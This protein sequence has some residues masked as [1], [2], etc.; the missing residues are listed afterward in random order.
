[1][2]QLGVCL[3]SVALVVGAAPLV[4]AQADESAAA[5]TTG[6]DWP[7]F[8][9]PTGDSKSREVGFDFAWPPTGLTVRWTRPLGDSYGIGSVRDGKYYQF[10]YSKRGVATL[11]CLDRESGRELWHFSYDSEY[12]DL[13]NYAAGPR[14]SP[15]VD[16]EHVYLYGVEGMLYCLN[17]QNGAE[18]WKHDTTKRYGVIQN[19]F[20]VGSTPVLHDHLILVMIGGSPA[21]DQQLPP[22]QLDRVS[23]NQSGIVAFD[24]RTGEERYRLSNELASYAG[25]KVVRRADRAW[26]FAFMRGGLVAFDPATGAQDFFFP[27][28][29]KILESVNASTPVVWDDYVL[30]SETY[31]PGAALLKFRPGA[32]EE[33]WSDRRRNRD[34]ALQTHWNTP[35]YHDGYLY[36]CSGR[37]TQNAEL[38]CVE[39]VTGKVMWSEPGLSRMS[40]LYVDGHFIA[41]DEYG[42]LRVFK[43]NPK[44][45]DL[46]VQ[47]EPTDNTAGVAR[48]LL[49]YPAWAAPIV[50]HG[51]LYVRGKDRLVCYELPRK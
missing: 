42:T 51:L 8:L 25:L 22:G 23:G 1:M 34:K 12:E 38:R 6:D 18:V 17:G 39:A 50:S 27:W 48:P 7:Y 11:Y 14:T 15:V 3:V 37:H 4:R 49:R 47:W 46:V 5:K 9:G 45:F 36:G 31:G 21:E 13:Y 32:Y 2:R 33:V 30:I 40:L 29:A 16:D 44:Q 19:F 10:D 35:I 43:A 24:K 20:G 41:L 26:A 28:R